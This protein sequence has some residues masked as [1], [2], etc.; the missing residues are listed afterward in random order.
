[1]FLIKFEGS[2]TAWCK[3][4]GDWSTRKYKLVNWNH[5]LL[6]RPRRDLK[7][8]FSEF[9]RECCAMTHDMSGIVERAIDKMFKQLQ[10]ECILLHVD[11]TVVLCKDLAP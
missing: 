8:P 6:E 4:N 5:E 9:D 2:F 11:S 10:C 3:H 7:Q 1:M